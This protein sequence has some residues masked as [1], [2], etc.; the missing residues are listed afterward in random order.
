MFDAIAVIFLILSLIWFGS[1]QY[2]VLKDR[3]LQRKID[4]RFVPIANKLG[5][6]MSGV[7]NNPDY[8]YFYDAYKTAGRSPLWQSKTDPAVYISPYR[9]GSIQ[10]CIRGQYNL[11]WLRLEALHNKSKL[12]PNISN[13]QINFTEVHLEGDFPKYFRLYCEAGY[14]IIALQIFSPEIMQDMIDRHR[15]CDVEI[16]GAAILYTLD[17]KIWTDEFIQSAIDYG[18][19][20]NRLA[21]A[22]NKVRSGLRSI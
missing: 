21:R 1:L 2:I 7:S 9:N 6:I 20:L 12:L 16:N 13:Y 18:L 22:V 5:L 15:F 17:N 19:T 14:E 8:A 11:P 10:A 4:R 3:F